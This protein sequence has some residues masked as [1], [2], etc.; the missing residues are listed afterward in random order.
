MAVHVK[1]KHCLALAT[2]REVFLCRLRGQKCI[3]LARQLLE[4]REENTALL[5]EWL[6]QKLRA[7]ES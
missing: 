7:E 3:Y 6:M 2:Y 4:E 1:E 5:R